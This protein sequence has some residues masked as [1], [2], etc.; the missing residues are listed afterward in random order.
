[1]KRPS[2]ASALY[3]GRVRHHRRTPVEHSFC[4]PLFMTY[5]DLEEADRLFA[6]RW[7]W[8]AQRR[9]LAWLRREDHFGDP[10]TPLI[11]AVRNLVSERTGSRPKGPVR[12]LTHLRM[13]GHTFNPVSF[14]FC[15]APPAEPGATEGPL[16][17]VVAE[18]ANTPWK[19]RHCYVLDAAGAERIGPDGERMRF[20]H[21]KEFH[22]SPFIG[23]DVDYVWTFSL[24]GEKL[25]IQ[26]DNF[27]HGA[28]FFAATLALERH[29]ATG[30]QLAWALARFPLMT[31]QIVSAI[32]FQAAR[33][34]WKRAPFFPHPKAATPPPPSQAAAEGEA[35]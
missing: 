5:L 17:A 26:V 3:F 10:A 24:P 33:L 22:V 9:T 12:L 28:R 32:Y 35:P 11:D 30:P 14:F 4:Y 20:R 25:A 23:M 34:W 13:F 15:F 16:A 8:S 27:D 21:R 29:E 18:V 7:F 1:M 6:R 31:L 2:F 19:E